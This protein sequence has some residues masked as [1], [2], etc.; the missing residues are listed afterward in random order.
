MFRD[1]AFSTGYYMPLALLSVVVV[2]GRC[3]LPCPM[4]CPSQGREFKLH[5]HPLHKTSTQRSA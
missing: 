4:D 5:S 1:W 3:T 2:V